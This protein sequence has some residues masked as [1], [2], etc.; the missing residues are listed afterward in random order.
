MAIKKKKK[1]VF[2]YFRAIP[3][4]LQNKLMKKG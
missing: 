2:Y 3:N 4:Y 1:K